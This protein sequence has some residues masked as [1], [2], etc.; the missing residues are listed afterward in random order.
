[1]VGIMLNKT[2]FLREIKS[3]FKL[4]LIFGAVLALYCVVVTA[5]YDP[6]LGKSLALMAETMPELFSAFGMSNSSST[7]TDF[8]SNYLYGF[9][10]IVFPAIFI[11]LLAGRLIARYVDRGSMVYLLSAPHKR[12]SIAITQAVFL[13]VMVLFLT[14]YITLICI[15][16][17][18]VL[19][20]NELNLPAFLELNLGLFCVLFF[21]GGVCYLCSCLFDDARYSVGLGAGLVIAFI[22]LQMLSQV[23]SA[24]ENLKYL[25]PLTL[26]QPLDMIKG[27]AASR[28]VYLLAPAGVLCYGA[29]VKIFS[30][31]D[32]S[33]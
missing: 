6:D 23:G 17:S 15:L 10:V 32:L 30:R 33:I 7:L 25:T 20:P 2:L 28:L 24:A 26:F 3:N 16:T 8:L 22:L 5:M 13:A 27:S 14:I 18:S 9:I 19:F 4:L 11:V 1:M 21:L 31:R 12:S 29:G